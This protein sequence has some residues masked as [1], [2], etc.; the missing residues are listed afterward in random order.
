MSPRISSDRRAAAANRG[1]LSGISRIGATAFERAGIWS[2]LRYRR[3][4]GMLEM[5]L[6]SWGGEP[7]L[8]PALPSAWLRGSIRGFRVRGGLRVDLRW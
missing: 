3:D 8:L 2:L 7:Q 6:Q 5:V 4:G 1:S